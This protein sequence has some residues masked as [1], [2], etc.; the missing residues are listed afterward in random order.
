MAMLMDIANPK[1]DLPPALTALQ[2]T[3]KLPLV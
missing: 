2:R 1:F 3:E